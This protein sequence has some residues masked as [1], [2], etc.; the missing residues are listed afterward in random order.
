MIALAALIAVV[1]PLLFDQP[2]ASWI[3]RSLVL[4]VIACPCALVI[5]T[6]VTIVLGLYQAARRGMLIKGGEHLERAGRITAVVF[7]KTGTLTTGRAEMLAVAPEPGVTEHEVLRIA[8]SLEQASDHPLAQAILAAACERGLELSPVSG[9]SALRGFGVQ[10]TLHG[11]T[12]FVGSPRMLEQRSEQ[13]GIVPSIGLYDPERFPA[14]KEGATLAVVGTR[15]RILGA[16]HLA[17]P[18]RAEGAEAIRELH[19]LG[20][21]PVMMLTGDARPVAAAIAHELGIDEVHAELLPDD[22]VR[23]VAEL[24]KRVPSLA[25]VGDGVNDAPALAASHL[26]IALG[27][28]ASDVARE[29]ADVV[30]ISPQLARVPELIRLGRRCRRLLAQNI[31]LSLAMKLLV[32]LLALA[33]LA[34][35]WMAVAADVGASLLVISNGMRLV[36]SQRGTETDEAQR[37]DSGAQRDQPAD[38]PMSGRG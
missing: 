34:T 33:D 32:L 23:E 17:D 36:G 16:I 11:E 18:P 30:I 8:A 31:A 3:H 38:A 37:A 5:S 25:M 9:F 24:A 2:F 7:D 13:L 22:K 4:L 15:D 21:Q 20:V 10:G 28:G 35:M 27:S 1:P 6:P 26:G 29:T 14:I 12:Y 19:A